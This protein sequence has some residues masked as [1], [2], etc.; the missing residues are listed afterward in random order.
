MKKIIFP[1]LLGIVILLINKANASAVVFGQDTPSAKEHGS[2]RHKTTV[3]K[4][5]PSTNLDAGFWT[6]VQSSLQSA[7]VDV[8]FADDTYT[9]TSTLMVNSIGHNTHLLTLKPAQ[10]AG[11][12]VFTGTIANLLKFTDCRNLLVQGLKFTGGATGY[13]VTFTNS[14]NIVIDNCYFTDL[15]KVFFGALGVHTN[16]DNVIVKNCTFNRVGVDSHAH[17]VY[18]AYGVTRLKLI[19][20]A[21]TDCSGAFVRFRGN[22]ST[23][24]VVYGN[25][26]TSTGTYAGGVNPGFIEVPVFNDVNPGDERFGT[27]F[28]VTKNKFIYSTAGKQNTRFAMV[29]HHSGFNPPDRIHLITPED[30]SVLNNGTV[31]QKRAILLAKP[32]I[33]GRE[34]RFAGNTNKNVEYNV[35]YRCQGGY[36]AIAPFAGI[37]N[38]ESAITTTGVAKN[39]AEA[40]AF[41]DDLY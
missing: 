10:K 32:G 40:L 11:S 6:A 22:L 29:F 33:D 12:A 27:S 13:A 24:G 38:I 14:K 18:G 36:G 21:F 23:H 4:V 2:D 25:T 19:N 16:S 26:F 35:L 31:D 5:K 39:E 28:M 30:A 17:L 8:V 15:Q 41:Y 1:A 9:R 37:A 34:V 20:N 3:Y 7:P